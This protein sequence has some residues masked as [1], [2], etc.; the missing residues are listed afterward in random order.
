MWGGRRWRAG[1]L[2]FLLEA[3]PRGHAGWLGL[4]SKPVIQRSCGGA[5]KAEKCRTGGEAAGERMG[6]WAGRGSEERRETD[7]KT[8]ETM[9]RRRLQS[10]GGG[11]MRQCPVLQG[12]CVN[13]LLTS[14]GGSWGPGRTLEVWRTQPWGGKRGEG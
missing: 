6:C 11:W 9:P 1:S 8:E 10:T 2:P 7:G 14:F 4:G 5:R 3:C 12:C 13:L